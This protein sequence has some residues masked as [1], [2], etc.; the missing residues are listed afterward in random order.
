MILMQTCL[1][2]GLGLGLGLALGL[3]LGLGLGL[4]AGAGAG[5]E[6][7]LGFDL[8]ADHRARAHVE[9]LHGP[10]EDPG[11]EVLDDSVPARYD[12]A[13]VDGEVDRLLQPI[14]L[15]VEDDLEAEVV[16][17]ALAALHILLLVGVVLLA[18]LTRGVGRGCAMGWSQRQCWGCA[19]SRET[20]TA[21]AWQAGAPERR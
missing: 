18:L 12:R 19:G 17:R 4:R 9:A 5:L 20:R 7:G 11:A 6:L 2:L 1:G 21:R 8:D 10:T 3:G 16:Q 15:R 14:P 13:H